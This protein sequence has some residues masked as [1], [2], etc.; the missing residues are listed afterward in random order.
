MNKR[1]DRSLACVTSPR[2]CLRRTAWMPQVQP[3]HWLTFLMIVKIHDRCLGMPWRGGSEEKD[4]CE[5]GDHGKPVL[6]SLQ[7]R[8]QQK[9]LIVWKRFVFYSKVQTLL[10]KTRRGPQLYCSHGIVFV[11]HQLDDVRLHF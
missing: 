8:I 7:Y 2:P 4:K 10:H 1:R 6:K 3:K 11:A 5:V 9:L